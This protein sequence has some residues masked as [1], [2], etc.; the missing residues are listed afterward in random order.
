MN[1]QKLNQ[2]KKMYYISGF[3]CETHFIP[4][5]IIEKNSMN[6]TLKIIRNPNYPGTL[7]IPTTQFKKQIGSYYFESIE[8]L[9][10]YDKKKVEREI[11][12]AKKRM[13]KLKNAYQDYKQKYN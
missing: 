8:D 13:E 9:Y 4:V 2:E 10:N 11:I 12:I 5:E 6:I 7:T 3:D 1:E